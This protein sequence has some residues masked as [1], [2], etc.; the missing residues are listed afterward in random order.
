[1]TS[2]EVPDHRNVS[3][4][5]IPKLALHLN[6]NIG[7]KPKTD[8]KEKDLCKNSN[9]LCECCSDANKTLAQNNE[10]LPEQKQNRPSSNKIT[11]HLK[12][13]APV[14]QTPGCKNCYIFCECCANRRK[15][16]Q[17]QTAGFLPKLA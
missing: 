11:K 6:I 3:Y 15:A 8:I 7:I 12:L 2:P 5:W 14:R 1:M 4:W 10:T 17:Y 13:T 9:I 16:K